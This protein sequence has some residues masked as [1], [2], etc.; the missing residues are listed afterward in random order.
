[1]PQDI[2][3]SKFRNRLN[4]LENKTSN[5]TVS[6]NTSSFNGDVDITGNLHLI[7]TTSDPVII[8]NISDGNFNR[9]LYQK[10]SRTWSAGQ[11]N[12][13][14]FA[15]ADETAGSYRMFIDTD[16]DVG[17]GTT[18]PATNLHVYETANAN[19]GIFVD[20][21]NA[22]YQTYISFAA[23]GSTVWQFGRQGSGSSHQLF[24]YDS[25][26]SRDIIRANTGTNGNLLLQPINGNVGIG[27][28]IPTVALHVRN[29]NTTYSD[30]E[31]NNLPTIFA[32]NTNNASLTAHSILG[33]RVNGAGGGDPFIAFDIAGV[34]G[35]SIGVD[36]SDSDKFK[37]S[38]NWSDVGTATD[39][40]IQTN[41][42]VGIGTT[43]PSLQGSGTGLSIVGNQYIQLQ[44]SGTSAGG[45][46]FNCNGGDQYEIQ[47][48][49]NDA[50][51]IY[52]RTDGAYRLY[53][54]TAGNVGINTTAPAAELD[55]NNGS[56]GTTSGNELEALRLTSTVSNASVLRFFTRR[57]ANGTDWFTAATRI[58]QTIDGGK[59]WLNLTGNINGRN[60]RVGMRLKRIP[61]QI[62]L[63][64]LD[65]NNPTNLQIPSNIQSP[66]PNPKEANASLLNEDNVS[67][68]N[69]LKL[70]INGKI[71]TLAYR[72]VVV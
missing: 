34:T 71:D 40:T 1:M 63:N 19:N 39:V 52:N 10:P 38:N 56:L 20:T 23:T 70:K 33:T 35:W 3:N 45:I 53:I 64:I 30:P 72:E 61:Y 59:R 26:G 6:N 32:T 2:E 18:S 29:A 15:I 68:L 22:G 49:N 57:H 51:F 69:K 54:D 65:E 4:N 47:A 16:G 21:S 25:A 31:N 42:N 14:N 48:D 7:S 36:N 28:T 60:N 13:N 46:Q 24:L 27:T 43:A 44:V 9:I 11:T 37:I 50:F 58:Q 66:S 5:V 12:G 67:L 41:G 55:I 62:L 8:Q 17:I